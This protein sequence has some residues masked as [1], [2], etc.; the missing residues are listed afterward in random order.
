MPRLLVAVLLTLPVFVISMGELL[1]VELYPWRNWMLLALTL[2]VVCYSGGG[3]FSAAW[4]AARNGYADM[5]T[6]VASGVMAALGLST[7]ATARPDWLHGA[8]GGHVY[9]E[10]AATIV[11]F[12]LTGRYLEAFARGRT[13]NALRKLLELQPNTAR[14]LRQ[15]QE[16][17][18]PIASLARGD[19][20]IVRPGE[21]ISVDGV[22]VSGKSFVDEA[23]I[24]GEPLPVEKKVGS[25]VIGGTLNTSGKFSISSHARRRGDAAASDRRTRARRRWARRRP[26]R[27]WR[28]ASHAALF[29]RC[30]RWR[31]SQPCAGCIGGPRRS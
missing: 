14:T 8:H 23:S 29:R 18:V 15:G 16:M 20:V 5:N 25:N 13:Q 6:L 17:D 1:P 30:S 27:N 4:T 11:T 12:I 2:P 7:V 21:K 28:I 3:F 10:S 22:V 24:S 26:S 31:R 9:F 19:V